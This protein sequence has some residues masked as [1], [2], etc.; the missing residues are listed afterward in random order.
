MVR[1]YELRVAPVEEKKQYIFES[2]SKTNKGDNGPKKEWQME[3]ERRKIRAQKKEQRRKQLDEVKEQQKNSWQNFNNKA[4]VKSLKADFLYFLYGYF[5]NLGNQAYRSFW[6]CC[7]W[8]AQW[9]STKEY[10][11][12]IFSC[13][14]QTRW[15]PWQDGFLVLIQ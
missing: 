3:R 4:S 9:T 15:S 10:C 1:L 5:S 7:W 11:Y 2:N 6:I 14:R 8:T 12:H 13:S